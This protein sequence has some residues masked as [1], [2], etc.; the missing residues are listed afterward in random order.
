MRNTISSSKEKIFPYQSTLQFKHNGAETVAEGIAT[1]SPMILHEKILQLW[2]S[3][4]SWALPRE[5]SFLS[6]DTQC[7]HSR[8]AA[9][10]TPSFRAGERTDCT[11]R[12]GWQTRGKLWEVHQPLPPN[13]NG[14]QDLLCLS[15]WREAKQEGEM[16]ALVIRLQ[17]RCVSFYH[18]R[19]PPCKWMCWKQLVKWHLHFQQGRPTCSPTVLT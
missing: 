18:Q 15:R 17:T 11:V 2:R 13:Y 9:L 1:H 3:D 19:Q 7:P 12:L 5:H 6:L 14:W 10:D 8:S 4:D 16:V